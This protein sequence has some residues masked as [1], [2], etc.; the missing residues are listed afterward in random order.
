M[1]FSPE[2]NILKR[3]KPFFSHKVWHCFISF[4]LLKS[5]IEA[6]F[7]IMPQNRHNINSYVIPP[8]IKDTKLIHFFICNEWSDMKSRFVYNLYN[9]AKCWRKK[10][11]EIALKIVC[12]RWEYLKLCIYIYICVCVSVCIYVFIHRQTLL[13]HNSSVVRP[14][15]SF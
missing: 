5:S 2:V 12:I 4:Y 3:I 1:S 8:E 6:Q 13:F 9:V 11:P 15:T 14:A 10:N 7:K